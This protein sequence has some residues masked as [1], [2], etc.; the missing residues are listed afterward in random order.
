LLKAN[1]MH[2]D[3]LSTITRSLMISSLIYASPAWVGFASADDLQRLQGPVKRA[4]KWGLLSSNKDLSILTMCDKADLSLFNKVVSLGA[5]V[6]HSMLP[7][8]QSHTHHLRPRNHPYILP[9]TSSSLQRNF[10]H[11]MLFKLSGV[12]LPTGDGQ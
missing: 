9:A 6:L 12:R 11:R 3:L 5:H 10:F 4:L 7:P 1:G 8:V 2:L